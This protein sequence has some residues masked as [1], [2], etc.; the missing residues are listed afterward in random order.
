MEIMIHLTEEVQSMNTR[1]IPMKEILKAPILLQITE[2]LTSV[3]LTIKI[4]SLLMSIENPQGMIRTIKEL[5][6]KITSHR[7]K[8]ALNTSLMIQIL[9]MGDIKVLMFLPVT[10]NQT[11]ILVIQKMHIPLKIILNHSLGHLVTVSSVL[12]ELM[13]GNHPKQSLL[14]KRTIEKEIGRGIYLFL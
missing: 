6:L 7:E 5:A 14:L 11:I 2:R 10:K 1:I 9:K 13:S 12:R 3:H 8:A 4:P